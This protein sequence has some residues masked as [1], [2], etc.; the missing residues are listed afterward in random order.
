MAGNF[1]VK[2]FQKM[3]A[4]LRMIKDQLNE[5]YI[6]KTIT[7][8]SLITGSVER[9]IDSLCDTIIERCISIKKAKGHK[10]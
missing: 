7:E 5:I 10:I 6:R 4:N 1:E 9:N 8:S 2:E 3:E